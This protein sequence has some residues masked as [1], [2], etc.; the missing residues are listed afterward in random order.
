MIDWPLLVVVGWFYCI[1]DASNMLEIW[2]FAWFLD[3]LS[4]NCIEDWTFARETVLLSLAITSS[5]STIP[6]PETSEIYANLFN[7]CY[8]AVKFE[9]STLIFNPDSSMLALVIFGRP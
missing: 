1:N 7:V 4:F 5:K 2:A 6:D 9:L 3:N 8:W